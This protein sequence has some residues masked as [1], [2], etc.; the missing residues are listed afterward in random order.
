MA[1]TG[2]TGEVAYS[3]MD[4]DFLPTA[5]FSVT[6]SASG[7]ADAGNTVA[8][9]ANFMGV[10]LMRMYSAAGS[11]SGVRLNGGDGWTG[12][13]TRK[14]GFAVRA[15]WPTC[16]SQTIA[17]IGFNAPTSGNN[18]I[19]IGHLGGV[20]NG[21]HFGLVTDTGGIPWALS[22]GTGTNTTVALT[23]DFVTFYVYTT[24]DGVY[25]VRQKGAAADCATK[26]PGTAI[27]SGHVTQHYH[28]YNVGTTA[29]ARYLQVDYMAVLGGYA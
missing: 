22:A 8:G 12:G 19:G 18:L 7:G 6:A 11:G 3:F 20:T 29:A 13:G 10:G 9:P 2:L 25:R 27:T 23:S 26:T 1:L 21:T 17:M 4:F 15:S 28:M 5:S 24:G 14:W 16:D